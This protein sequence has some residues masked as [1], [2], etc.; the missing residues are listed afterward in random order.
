MTQRIRFLISI[1]WSCVWW[2]AWRRWRYEIGLSTF[3]GWSLRTKG[4]LGVSRW[5]TCLTVV[6]SRM[7]RVESRSRSM[8]RACPGRCSFW[9]APLVLVNPGRAWPRLPVGRW[10]WRRRVWWIWLCS[11]WLSIRL[12]IMVQSCPRLSALLRISPPRRCT[13]AL[14]PLKAGVG[15]AEGA[16]EIGTVAFL[17]TCW[18]WTKR[19]TSCCWRKSAGIRRTRASA[20]P[21]IQTRFPSIR[22]IFGFR[23]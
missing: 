23:V 22:V 12:T 5:P 19:W 9:R 8:I 2:G 3:C 18:R 1:R 6:G 16:I 20:R 7:L 15:V 21:G 11:T 4:M 17:G 10:R 13:C 14:W